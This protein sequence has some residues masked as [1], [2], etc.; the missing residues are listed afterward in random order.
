MLDQYTTVSFLFHCKEQ[1]YMPSLRTGQSQ[2]LTAV[3]LGGIILAAITSAF[4]WGL[5]LIEKNQ[6]VQTAQET[7]DDFNDLSDVM[8]QVVQEG[9]SRSETVE[10]GT[11]TM[12]IDTEDDM[13]TYQTMHR[14]AYVS[15]GDWVPLNEND[16][17]GVPGTDGED[18]H[19]IRGVDRNGV[20]VGRAE[21]AGDEYFTE[22][23]VVFRPL[24]DPGSDR[25]YQVELVQNG[26]LQAS[27]GQQ[28]VTFERGETEIEPGEG[29]NGGPLHRI[30]LLIRVS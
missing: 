4:L 10:L 22:Y 9:G 28:S 18:G 8:E 6:D 20:L 29:V 3:I 21:P 2:V 12:N 11:G 16:V 30:P 14:G 15:V 23:R 7:L 13:I 25:T 19:G 5:P 24:T 26:N 27:G 1:A 17:Q